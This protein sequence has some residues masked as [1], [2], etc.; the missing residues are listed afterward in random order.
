[1]AKIGPIMYDINKL[2]EN[3]KIYK[4]IELFIELNIIKREAVKTIFGK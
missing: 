2:C 1:M 3:T 4:Q